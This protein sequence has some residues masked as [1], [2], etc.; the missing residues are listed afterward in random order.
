[1]ED[2]IPPSLKWL[3]DKRARIHGEILRKNR[4]HQINFEDGTKSLKCLQ[5]DIQAIDRVIGLHDIHV[6]PSD[7]P[8]I[9]PQICKFKLPY[10]MATR[11]IYEYFR[12]SQD[13]YSSTPMIVDYAAR[14]IGISRKSNTY[15]YQ[16]LYACFCRR[17]CI[18]A[19]HGKLKG[20]KR[21]NRRDVKYWA[22]N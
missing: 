1:M 3:I 14:K 18:L 4:Q 20:R 2:R 21:E 16:S 5:E 8:P 9:R 11:L 13:E 6:N 22:L 17:L 12:Q 19:S 7:I 15:E 10:G